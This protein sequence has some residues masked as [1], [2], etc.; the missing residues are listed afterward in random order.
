MRNRFR[1]SKFTLS[2]NRNI[3]GAIKKEDDGYVF[4]STS[5]WKRYK[6]LKFEQSIGNITEL[7]VHPSFELDIGG[8]E[9]DDVEGEYCI[10]SADFK[11]KNSKGEEI[12][13]DVKSPALYD[14]QT[15]RLKLRMLKAQYGIKVILIHPKKTGILPPCNNENFDLPDF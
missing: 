6:R 7:E 14:D 11:Y 15:L 8:Q 5:E 2:G 9:E 13:E 4:D 12:V 1:S 3:F 10:Y